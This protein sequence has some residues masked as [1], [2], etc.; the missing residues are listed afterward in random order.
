MRLLHRAGMDTETLRT[1]I[2]V[3]RAGGFS[4]AA[5]R[6]NRSQPAI[7]R[8]I[9]LLEAELGAPVF[10][11]TTAGVV[12]SEVGRALFPHAERALAAL[13]DARS[14]VAELRSGDA[15]S[16]SLAVVGT[17][18]G[19]DLTGVLKRFAAAAPRVELSLSTATSSQVSDL[20]RRGGATLGLRY[21]ED[22]SPDLQCHAMAA[23]VLV[24]ACSP[25]HPLA[26]RSV[27]GLAGLAGEHWL[28]FPRHGAE[29]EIAAETIAAQ[30]LV[31]HVGQFRWTAVD[32]LTAQKRL[33]EAGFGISLMPESSLVEERRAGTLAV[34]AVEDLEAFNPVFAVQ[35]REGYLSAA[36]RALL[37]MLMEGAS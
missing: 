29:G 15:G 34:I 25:E 27:R 7:S 22:R 13:E 33:V 9:A 37:G 23:E 26:G 21:F 17:L 6:L 36:A 11:R 12:L 35:R 14:A 5:G 8:R 24:V 10:E 1:F 3:H 4:A 28:A 16:L 31:R 30:F 32:S 20:V 18:A 2:A 19:P